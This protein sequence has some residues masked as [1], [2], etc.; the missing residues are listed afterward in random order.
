MQQRHYPTAAA[1]PHTSQQI[2]EHVRRDTVQRAI[3]QVSPRL[4]RPGLD[5]APAPEPAL[6]LLG[7]IWTASCPT[8]GYQLA[9]ARTQERVER[10]AARRRCPVCHEDGR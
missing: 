4:D 10:R 7:G 8:C 1:V 2:D 5:P 3:A 6:H 9:T